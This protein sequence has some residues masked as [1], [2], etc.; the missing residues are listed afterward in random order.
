MLEV[1]LKDIVCALRSQ[2]RTVAAVTWWIL[3]SGTT[4]ETSLS[5]ES[6]NHQ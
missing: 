4:S 3:R 2:L 1:H 5:M 6:V